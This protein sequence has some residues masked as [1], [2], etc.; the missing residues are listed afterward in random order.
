[1]WM[2]FEAIRLVEGVSLLV[3]VSRD[4]REVRELHPGLLAGRVLH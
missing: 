3:R 2:Q 1:M 4:G